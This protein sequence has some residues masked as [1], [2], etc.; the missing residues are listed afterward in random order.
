MACMASAWRMYEVCK[1]WGLWVVYYLLKKVFT[2]FVGWLIL[3]CGFCFASA[4]N[5]STP[6]NLLL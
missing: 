2:S 6:N 3:R 5:T 1:A 4:Y